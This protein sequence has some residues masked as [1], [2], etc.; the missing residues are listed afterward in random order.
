MQHSLVSMDLVAAM[1]DAR[2]KRIEAKISRPGA[3]D[4]VDGP[5]ATVLGGNY[6]YNQSAR[7]IRSSPS[8]SNGVR[9]TLLTFF[10]WRLSL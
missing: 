8:L 2:I 10:P 1:S 4:A 6:G 9:R 7:F 5:M 3:A